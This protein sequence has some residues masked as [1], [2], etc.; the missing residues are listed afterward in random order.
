MQ[1]QSISTR[2]AALEEDLRQNQD[3]LKL[4]SIGSIAGLRTTSGICPTCLQE[5]GDSLIPNGIPEKAMSVDQ[6]I[7]F[8]QSQKITFEKMRSA[9]SR[10]LEAKQMRF[11]ALQNELDSLR[12]SIRSLQQTLT[13]DARMPSIADVRRRVVLEESLKAARR[14][15]D[16]FE[17]HM[18]RF[19]SVS[20]RW[21]SLREALAELPKDGL[22]PSDE[23]K[24]ALLESLF[25]EQVKEYGLTSVNPETLEISRDTYKPTREG[26]DLIFELSASDNIRTIWA[27]LLGLLEMSRSKKT[28]HLG[29]LILDEPRQQETADL[30]FAEFLRRASRASEFG[31]QI[32][33]ATSEPQEDLLPALVSIPHQYLNY[34]GKI[35]TR[36]ADGAQSDK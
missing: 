11:S 21:R 13:S 25:V 1:L 5:I 31:Q 6:S 34:N 30:S 17:S 4:T 8:I 3:I 7:R 36:L 20:S 15:S 18:E 24:I 10:D 22:S 28:N 16:E 35:I 9:G 33:F 29:L 14:I 26:F 32:I 23:A 19:I 12:T 27:Y 2:L